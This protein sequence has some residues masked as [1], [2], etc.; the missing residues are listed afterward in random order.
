MGQSNKMSDK[1]NN[2]EIQEEHSDTEDEEE[3][4]GVDPQVKEK[5][6][7]AS[8]KRLIKIIHSN[9]LEDSRENTPKLAH[10]QDKDAQV[11]EVNSGKEMSRKISD[12]FSEVTSTVAINSQQ[13]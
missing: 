3:E 4:E 7:K 10:K 11:E 8:E 1:I 6:R 12:N 2:Q 5:E 13:K 9:E